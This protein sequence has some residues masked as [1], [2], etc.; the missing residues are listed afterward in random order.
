MTE[1]KKAIKIAKSNYKEFKNTPTSYNLKKEFLD[2]IVSYS[3][4]MPNWGSC[5][6]IV[7]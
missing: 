3:N 5:N 2:V 4:N 1:E 6:I 7:L